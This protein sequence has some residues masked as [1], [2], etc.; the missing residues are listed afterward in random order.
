MNE[1]IF[2]EIS[3]IIRNLDNNEIKRFYLYSDRK[4]PEDEAGHKYVNLFKLY[5]KNKTELNSEILIKEKAKEF[6]NSFNDLQQKLRDELVNFIGEDYTIQKSD[7]A[8]FQINLLINQGIAL[9]K[10]NLYTLSLRRFQMAI[11]LFDIANPAIINESKMYLALKLYSNLFNVKFRASKNSKS[12]HVLNEFEKFIIPFLFFAQDSYNIFFQKNK[13]NAFQNEN[14]HKSSFY[15]LINLYLRENLKFDQILNNEN[16]ISKSFVK[17]LNV[18]ESNNSDSIVKESLVTMNTWLI[19]FERLYSAL[20]TNKHGEFEYIFSN[21]KNSLFHGTFTSYYNELILF[22]Y[23]KLF[24]LQ[25]LFSIRENNTPEDIYGL[26]DLHKITI[27]NLNLFTKHEIS[28]I[29]QRIEM[30]KFIILFLEKNYTELLPDLEIVIKQLEATS[31]YYL[32]LIALELTARCE[33]GAELFKLEKTTNKYEKIVEKRKMKDFHYIFCKFMIK[34]NSDSY[35]KSKRGEFIKSS[36]KKMKENNDKF[37]C[38][39][40]LIINWVKSKV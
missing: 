11:E 38:Y 40:Q 16:G 33:S 19:Q 4:S 28:D 30:N 15:S 8:E 24:E 29:S 2:D 13:L 39:H 18:N 20:L 1:R 31:P 25:T 35:G 14:F 6:T 26:K 37:N 10:K 32:D 21:L 12:E 23:R 7:S 17:L 34:Y 36:L 27:D 9:S 5:L 22:L 3:D